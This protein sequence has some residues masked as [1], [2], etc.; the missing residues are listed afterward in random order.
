M[1]FSQYEIDAKLQHRKKFAVRAAAARNI[2]DNFPILDFRRQ[3]F[4]LGRVRFGD[5]AKSKL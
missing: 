1:Q 5:G 2:Y 4:G 3:I